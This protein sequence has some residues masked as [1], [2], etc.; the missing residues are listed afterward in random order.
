MR[1]GCAGVQSLAI[2]KKAS[3]ASHRLSADYQHSHPVKIIFKGEN[4]QWQR[5]AKWR[6]EKAIIFG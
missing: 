2:M 1:Y 6:G 4:T 3:V 5:P